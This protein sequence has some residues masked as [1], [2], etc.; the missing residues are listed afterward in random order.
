MLMCLACGSSA[1][2]DV[3]TLGRLGTWGVFAAGMA[4]GAVVCMTLC[5]VAWTVRRRFESPFQAH[6]KLKA[7]SLDEEEMAGFLSEW[8]ASRS[9]SSL[10]S[11]TPSG[12]AKVGA[13][14]AISSPSIHQQ[15]GQRGAAISGSGQRSL[16]G[17]PASR[18]AE[19]IKRR[20]Q[21]SLG[22]LEHMLDAPVVASVPSSAPATVLEASGHVEHNVRSKWSA[23]VGGLASSTPSPSHAVQKPQQR[24]QQQP[25]PQRGTR[26]HSRRPAAPA[27]RAPSQT[28]G[29]SVLTK[30]VAKWEA[31]EAALGLELAQAEAVGLVKRTGDG[32]LLRCEGGRGG[33]QEQPRISRRPAERA[34]DG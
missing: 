11:G 13:G 10:G 7:A 34:H 21:T 27:V 2:I 8:K 24:R 31:M 19:L 9:S 25:P 17:H 16:S 18:R 32:A 20:A 33:H 23:A 3:L 30:E 12:V 4:T 29:D 28:N 22:T 15:Q 1:G 26:E 14:T 6:G 5:A